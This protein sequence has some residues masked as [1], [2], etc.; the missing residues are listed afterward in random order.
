MSMATLWVIKFLLLYFIIYNRNYNK[1]IKQQ[2][3]AVYGYRYFIAKYTI[4]VYM[5]QGDLRQPHSQG[6][7]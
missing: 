6:Y 5:M 2:K 7:Y 3:S 4:P 1:P